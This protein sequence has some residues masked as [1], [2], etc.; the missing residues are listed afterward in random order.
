MTASMWPH[1]VA[2]SSADFSALRSIVEREA[3]LRLPESKREVVAHRVGRRLRA[4]AMPSVG[5]YLTVLRGGEDRE[6]ELRALI[7]ELTTNLTSFFREAHHF[8][9]LAAS[10]RRGLLPRRARIWSAA[11]STGEEPYTIAMV[12]EELGAEA[13]AG[14]I[15]ATDIDTDVL[16]TAARGIYRSEQ[17]AQLAPGRVRGHFLRGVGENA[18]LCAVRPTLRRRVQFRR[19]NLCGGLWPPP[20]QR[21]DLVFCR[22]VLIYF[23]RTRQRDVITRLQRCLV[24]GGVLVLGHS[25]GLVALELGL[26]AI[27]Q[28]IYR[29]PPGAPRPART[30]VR[31]P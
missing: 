25:E 23:E 28:T 3:G 17:V 15:V 11:C 14:Q 26:E 8:Q 12:L 6:R 7:N 22:N 4:R 2:L 31:R 9:F 21:F 16:A 10:L 27:G 1:D 24:P 20:S 5:A 18:G 30:L 19:F 13:I 29:V